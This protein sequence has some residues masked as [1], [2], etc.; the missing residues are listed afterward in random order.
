MYIP[1]ALMNV[2]FDFKFRGAPFKTFI[3]S[4]VGGV[5]AAYYVLS[6]LP[7]LWPYLA[8]QVIAINVIGFMLWRLGIAG[9]DDF[10]AFAVVSPLLLG[11]AFII[12]AAAILLPIHKIYRNLRHLRDN[13]Y[14]SKYPNL[15]FAWPF[16][17]Y[18]GVL[19]VFYALFVL[20]ST[21]MGLNLN[22]FTPV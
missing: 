6:T 17:G 20:I 9:N 4:G 1:S 14:A 22:F 7:Q 8:A 19:T 2:Y 15:N 12:V 16:D 11:G 13:P 18:V 3:F 21:M 10:V 5:L